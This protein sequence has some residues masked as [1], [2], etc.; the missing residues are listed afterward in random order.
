MYLSHLTSSIENLISIIENGLIFFP[1]ERK[2]FSKL[3]FIEGKPDLPEPQCKGMI[4][5]TDIPH[6]AACRHRKKYGE[7]GIAIQK[8]W[9]TKHGACKVIYMQ[10]NNPIFD[11]FHNLFKILTPVPR[12]LENG[13]TDA[14]IEQ[15]ARTNAKFAKSLGN[16]AYAE[17][18]KLHEYMQTD[19]HVAESEW[20]II[21]PI[22]FAFSNGMELAEIKKICLRAGK[23]KIFPNLHVTPQ[24]T[25]F[26]ICPEYN[27]TELQKKLPQQWI[28]ISIKTH[29]P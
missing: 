8:N 2:V 21:R 19:E 7:F 11:A 4:S 5:F 6:E 9:A 28:N 23:N 17:L 25:S 15:I 1:N 3:S 24:A 12:N 29:S 18:L 20:R 10:E 13:E 22:E 26:L 16:P 27:L 14:Y